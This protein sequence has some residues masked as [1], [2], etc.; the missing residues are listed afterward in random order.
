MCHRINLACVTSM[1]LQLEN[2]HSTVGVQYF[3]IRY[4]IIQQ[5]STVA[6][7]DLLILLFSF[8]VV[9]DMI[10]TG[11]YETQNGTNRALHRFF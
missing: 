8:R 11:T 1:I 2:G 10:F 5:M 6:I 4:K 3:K 9:V 7:I